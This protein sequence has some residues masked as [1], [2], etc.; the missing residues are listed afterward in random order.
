MPYAMSFRKSVAIV[1]R[2]QYINECCVGGDII[3]DRLLPSVRER[4]SGIQT[5]QEDWGWFIW[6]QDDNAKLA[7]DVHT[8]DADAGDFQ[9]RLTSRVKKLWFDKVA[10]TP[11]LDELRR[12]VESEL[13]TWGVRGLRVEQVED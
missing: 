3:V 1:D 9:I 6:F 10:D 12:L 8:E 5:N 7:I 4:Y 2:N 13:K 11:Q